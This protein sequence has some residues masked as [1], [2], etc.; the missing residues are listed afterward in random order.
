[1][2]N[3]VVLRN[4]YAYGFFLTDGLGKRHFDFVQVRS[5]VLCLHQG[6]HACIA[7]GLC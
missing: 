3:R 4:S 7:R 5:Q 6:N 2:Q 1:M